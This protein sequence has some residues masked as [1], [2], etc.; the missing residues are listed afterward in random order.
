MGRELEAACFLLFGYG[1]FRHEKPP[2]HRLQTQLQG[3]SVKWVNRATGQ[4]VHSLPDALAWR[5][6]RSSL[7]RGG[8]DAAAA[9]GDY[10]DQ[11]HLQQ[12]QQQAVAGTA[13]GVDYWFNWRTNVTQVRLLNGCQKPS[14]A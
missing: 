5:R 7:Q 11:E 3:K 10:D 2:A 13:D 6:R 8:R 14:S 12:Q 9:G 4:V 1:C